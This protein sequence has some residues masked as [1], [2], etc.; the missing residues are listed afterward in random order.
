MRL[1]RCVC[2]LFITTNGRKLAVYAASLGG[3]VALV[4]GLHI[5]VWSVASTGKKPLMDTLINK[6]GM[7]GI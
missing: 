2:G 1:G 7:H 4:L 6:G 5:S 3:V